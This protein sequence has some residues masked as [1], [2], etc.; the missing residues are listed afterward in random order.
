MRW[1]AVFGYLSAVV[2]AT[3]LLSQWLGWSGWLLVI[4]MVLSLPV[5]ALLARSWWHP[6][7]WSSILA[8]M[9]AV[10]L[11]GAL[12]SEF[13]LWIDGRNGLLLLWTVLLLAVAI[14]LF[15]HPMRGPAWGLFVGFWGTAAVIWLVVLQ[16][17]AVTGFLHG[18]A[19][20]AWVAWPLAIIGLW[21]LVA[22]ATGFGESPFGR[23]VDTL[24]LLT[25]AGLVSISIATWSG[26]EDLSKAIAAGA[27]VAY[28]LWTASL[29]WV[30]WTHK[31]P[32]QT[33]RGMTSPYP[34]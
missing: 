12:V 2:V 25:G 11:L 20:G 8:V 23:V 26:A 14:T 10:A 21:I 27:A 4:S 22:S 32:G 5:V 13:A 24:G 30:L 15:G 34:G 16:A 18:A 17:L 3:L 6:L 29:G 1:T 19:Y 31:R 28:C 7:R 33:I 9:S